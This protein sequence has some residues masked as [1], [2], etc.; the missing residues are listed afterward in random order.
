MLKSTLHK[1]RIT[2]E[3][4]PSDWRILIEAWWRLLYFHLA[5]RRVSYE[6]LLM[7]VQSERDDILDGTAVLPLAQKNQKLVHWAACLHFISM[8]CLDRSLTLH[9]ILNRRGVPAK[10]RIGVGKFQEG[11]QAHAWVEVC[12]ELLGETADVPARFG[13]LGSPARP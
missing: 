3:L 8:T 7:P 10:L 13:I 12:N 4:F 2:Q 6:R 1:L 9:W 5:L 11:F